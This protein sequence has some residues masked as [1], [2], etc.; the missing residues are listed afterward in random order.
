LHKNYLIKNPTTQI[1]KHYKQSLIQKFGFQKSNFQFFWIYII[2]IMEG[3]N[4]K[5]LTH[6]KE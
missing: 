6:K 3:I 2:F 4:S 5:N 1:S